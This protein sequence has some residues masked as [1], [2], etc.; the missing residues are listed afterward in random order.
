MLA[1]IHL[2]PGLYYVGAIVAGAVAGWLNSKEHKDDNLKKS[3]RDLPIKDLREK[4]EVK[5]ELRSAV[6]GLDNLCIESSDDDNN[7][8]YIC[9]KRVNILDL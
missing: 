5:S 4:E 3:S 8:D 7:D 1:V 6:D 2:L 9:D